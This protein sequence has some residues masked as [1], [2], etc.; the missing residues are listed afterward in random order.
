MRRKNERKAITAAVVFCLF[1]SSAYAETVQLDL[2]SIGCPNL[3]SHNDSWTSNIDIGVQFSQIDS[4]YMDWAGGITAGLAIDYDDPCNPFPM[5]V[6]IKAYFPS[7]ISISAT[8]WGGEP[9]YPNPEPFDIQTDF[10]LSPFDTWDPFLDGSAS[11]SLYYT[12]LVLLNSVYIEH[13]SIDLT[14]ANLVVEGVIVP[15]PSTLILFGLSAIFM[16]KRLNF[17]Q[18]S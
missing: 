5:D 9:N 2:F 14:K 17:K 13:G 6:G 1:I 4:V 8:L 3:F 11:F 12:E 15:D 18:A 16:R 7:P 10:G